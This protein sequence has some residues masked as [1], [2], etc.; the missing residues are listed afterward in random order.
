[1]KADITLMAYPDTLRKM[2]ADLRRLAI[3]YRI[4]RLSYKGYN[5][6]WN[7]QRGL[8]LLVSYDGYLQFNNQP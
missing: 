4:V 8:G 1:M 7:G 3:P 5:P 2:A 6:A